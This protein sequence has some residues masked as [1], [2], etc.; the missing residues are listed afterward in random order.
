MEERAM[1]TKPWKQESTQQAQG[2]KEVKIMQRAGLMHRWQ[3]GTC[4]QADN[5][6]QIM[7][8]IV[9]WSKLR[10]KYFVSIALLNPYNSEKHFTGKTAAAVFLF[11]YY[12]LSLIFLQQLKCIYLF[13][14]LLLKIVLGTQ[15][16][17]K[18]YKIDRW[19]N[20]Q[21]NKGILVKVPSPTPTI[22]T[23]LTTLTCNVQSL[24][25]LLSPCAG[26]ST[27]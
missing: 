19:L 25:V 21:T 18:A 9:H 12:L 13:P 6:T 22:F 16:T 7:A 17:L 27:H 5:G 26:P 1:Y 15:Q 20:E 3:L 8:S 4:C 14:W 24:L 2:F 10:D 11:S 23:T